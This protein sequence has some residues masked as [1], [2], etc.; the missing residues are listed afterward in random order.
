MRAVVRA[1][2]VDLVILARGGGSLE[3]LWCFNDEAL[4]RAIASCPVP[5][6]SAVGHETDFT[7]ADFVA[8]VRAPTPS[9]AAEIAVPVADELRAEL[10]LLGRRAARAVTA[11]V[12]RSRLLVERARR[13]IGDPR[14]LV[15]DRRQAVDELGSRAAKA[16]RTALQQ[17]RVALRLEETRLFRAHP[18]RRI[19]DQRKAL[20]ALEHRLGSAMRVRVGS[21]RGALEGMVAKLSTLSPLGVLERGYSLAL[22]PDGH[23]VTSIAQVKGGDPLLVRFHDG[24]A[25]TTVGQVVPAPEEGTSGE[26]GQQRG[27][28]PGGERKE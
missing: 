27:R 3:D 14:R 26:A 12:A 21:R 5:V 28:Q 17:R 2:D 22:R 19:G 10:L 8:D 16:L 23:L 1:R 18:Q 9:A 24:Q 20:H 11:E 6:I 15:E 7:I 13:R 4:A 25:Q